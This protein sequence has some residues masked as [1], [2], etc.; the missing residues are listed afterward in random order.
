MKS[1]ICWISLCLLLSSG[2]VLADTTLE[3]SVSGLLNAGS[4]TTYIKDG[5]VRRGSGAKSAYVLYNSETDTMTIVNPE[6]GSYRVLDKSTINAMGR[7]L[8]QTNQKARRRMQSLLADVPPSQRRRVKKMM[9]MFNKTMTDQVPPAQRR[10]MQGMMSTFNAM[11][12]Q[13]ELPSSSEVIVTGQQKT[14]NGFSCQVYTVS[15]PG[16]DS[17]CLASAG[18]LGLPEADYQALRDMRHFTASITKRLSRFIGIGPRIQALPAIEGIPVQA[19]TSAFGIQSSTTLKSVSTD[20]LDPS[21]FTIPEGFEK[22][23]KL[24]KLFHRD[25]K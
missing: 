10:R 6:Q 1:R 23:Q 13:K 21:L 3:R 20:S 18:E 19:H 24:T 25:Q 11:M 7:K 16:Q 8:A 17:V 22:R 5:M 9:R 2:A 15:G 12:D 4:R 14:I